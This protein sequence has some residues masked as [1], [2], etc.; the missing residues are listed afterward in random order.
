MEVK[1]HVHG[2]SSIVHI[3][4]GVEGEYLNGISQIPHS[5]L[6]EATSSNVPRMIKLAFL[7]EGID[8]MGG[9]GFMLSSEHTN[10]DINQT[11]YGFQNVLSALRSDRII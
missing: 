5:E 2:I 7:N 10:D 9:I 8:M 4:L 3:A 6:F 1:G 11:L